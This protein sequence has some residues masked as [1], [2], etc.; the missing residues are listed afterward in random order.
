MAL[1]VHGFSTFKFI[2]RSKHF[3][4]R[5]LYLT[6]HA[7]TASLF[8]IHLISISAT[9]VLLEFICFVIMLFTY[10]LYLL[11]HRFNLNIDRQFVA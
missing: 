1:W 6:N 3:F 9:F 4:Y 5:I 11:L 10:F 7:R 2:K 8:T